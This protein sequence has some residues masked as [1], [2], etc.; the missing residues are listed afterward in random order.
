MGVEIDPDSRVPVYRQLAAILRGQIA[1]GTLQPDRVLPS[2]ATLQQ[3]YGVSQGTVERALAAL[4]AEGLVVT[5]L[6]RGVFVLPP[7]E[8][9]PR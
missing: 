7:D 8:R 3:T 9:R 5:V 2:K 4:K 6:G 1:D